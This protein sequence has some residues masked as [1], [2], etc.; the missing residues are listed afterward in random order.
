MIAGQQVSYVAEAGMLPLLN[1]DGTSRASVFFVAYIKQDEKSMDRR[2]VTFCFN[3]GP[4]SS[5]VWLHLGALGPRR[6]KLSDKNAGQPAAFGL[7]DNEFSILPV[8]DLVF[9]DPVATGYSRPAGTSKAQQFFGEAPDIESVGEFIRLWTTRQGRW[10]SPKYVCGESY[11]VFRAAGLAHHLRSSYG[12]S[13]SG[14]IFVSG[15]VDFAS[16]S[17]DVGC[18]VLLP[19]YTAVAHFHHKLPPELQADLP[20]ALA[21]ARD[22]HA[23]GVCVGVVSGRIADGGRA[24]PRGREALAAYRFAG[25]RSRRQQFAHRQFDVPQGVVA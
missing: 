5:S 24:C 11:G 19:A 25:P 10:L 16:L 2:P 13:L 21:E 8:T 4:G 15:A 14:L 7:T 6:V 22:V 17:G 12:M 18:Q 20:K 9:I 1:S 3:G 23:D